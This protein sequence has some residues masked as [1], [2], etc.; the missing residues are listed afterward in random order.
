MDSAERREAI[1]ELLR[2]ASGPVSATALAK[3][4]S[5]SRQVVVGDVALLR[6]SGADVAATPRGYL[7]PRAEGGAVCTVVCRHRGED[8]ERELELVVDQ[9]C[10]VVDVIVEHPVYG[11]LTGDLHVSSRYDVRQ[12][13][14]R[15]ADAG[16]APLS[17]LTG[18]VHLHTL[19]GPDV[20]ALDR[21]RA[22]L[23]A[24]GFL[25]GE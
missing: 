22:A 4:F 25:V 9:G 17:A 2:G 12:F 21:A 13:A 15:V 23:D 3:R 6:A 7:I 14:Q 24:A 19:R 10:T 20:A 11:Q 1:L 5:V 16:A 8:L 18:G